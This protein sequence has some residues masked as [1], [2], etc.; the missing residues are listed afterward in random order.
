MV[1]SR[2]RFSEYREK[3]KKGV[4]GLFSKKK[5]PWHNACATAWKNDLQNDL[6][7]L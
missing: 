7:A 4:N 6:T 3:E 2:F 5:K 1:K